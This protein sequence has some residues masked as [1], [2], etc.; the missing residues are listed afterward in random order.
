[1]KSPKIFTI[2]VTALS[3]K[4]QSNSYFSAQIVLNYGMGEKQGEKLICLPYQYGYE[5]QYESAAFSELVKLGVIPGS[6]PFHSIRRY[7]EDNAIILRSNKYS[8]TKGE[9]TRFGQSIG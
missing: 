2:D 9:V 4:P 8:A 1:M 5:S 6:Y 7:C 3:C